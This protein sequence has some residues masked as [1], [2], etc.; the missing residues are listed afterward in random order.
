M[1]EERIYS[2]NHVTARSCWCFPR[3]N[4]HLNL[5]GSPLRRGQGS[6]EKSECVHRTHISKP[7][8]GVGRGAEERGSEDLCCPGISL[9]LLVQKAFLK[10]SPALGVKKVEVAFWSSKK[11]KQSPDRQRLCTGMQSGR[12]ERDEKQT[13]TGQPGGHPD[14]TLDREQRAR[15]ENQTLGF[16]GWQSVVWSMSTLPVF[17]WASSAGDPFLYPLWNCPLVLKT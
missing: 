7:R 4:Q 3:Y 5:E 16:P 9:I 14:Q 12:G 6:R 15:K 13:D 11:K 1:V 8:F 2:Q 10:M 17:I